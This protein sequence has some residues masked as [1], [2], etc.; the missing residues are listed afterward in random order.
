[1]GLKRPF[2]VTRSNNDDNAVPFDAEIIFTYL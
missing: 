1:M 2:V